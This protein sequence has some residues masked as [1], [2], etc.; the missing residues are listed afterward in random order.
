MAEVVLHFPKV[1]VPWTSLRTPQLPVLVSSL[2][3]CRQFMEI[4]LGIRVQA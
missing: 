4:Q 1:P 3:Q 2:V